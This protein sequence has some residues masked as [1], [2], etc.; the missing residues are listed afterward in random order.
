MV[1][2]G[3][4]TENVIDSNVGGYF[5]PFLKFSGF[6]ALE[7]QGKAA[8]DVLIF[9]DGDTGRVTVEPYA[10]EEQ[11][12]HLIGNILT[13]R[14]GGDE[15]GKRGVAV[16]STGQAADHIRYAAI[17][18]TWYDVRRKE[19]RVKQAGRGGAGRVGASAFFLRGGCRL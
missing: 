15:R 6:D 7:I 1:T 9:I 11:D 2:I 13:A 12:S 10:F 19:A 17:N 3:P 18:S 5:S 14:Y 4:L 8:E 16:L